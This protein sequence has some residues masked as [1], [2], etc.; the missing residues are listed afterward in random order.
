M[1]TSAFSAALCE[2]C[3]YLFSSPPLAVIRYKTHTLVVKI[4][5]Y[6]AY[7]YGLNLHFPNGYVKHLRCL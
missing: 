3:R 5:V 7:D 1:F 2:C 4:D 6:L